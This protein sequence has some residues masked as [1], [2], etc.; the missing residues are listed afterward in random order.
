MECWWQH[1][2]SRC[3]RTEA[4]AAAVKGIQSNKLQMH[5][6]Y[7]FDPIKC[8]GTLLVFETPHHYLLLPKDNI[9]QWGYGCSLLP[10]LCV[11]CCK[12]EFKQAIAQ[13][14][15]VSIIPRN[16]IALFTC[17][18]WN[19]VRARLVLVKYTG[20]LWPH[21]DGPWIYS[22]SWLKDELCYVHYKEEKRADQSLFC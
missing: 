6:K 9:R 16:C 11:I 8:C 18:V 22:G 3:G 20:L 19:R 2:L 13:L 15:H 17:L 1:Q 4:L 12:Y 10:V 14:S 21:H 7:R 5:I